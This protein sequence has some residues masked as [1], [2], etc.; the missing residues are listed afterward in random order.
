MNIDQVDLQ[1]PPHLQDYK[2]S[3]KILQM[4]EFQKRNFKIEKSFSPLE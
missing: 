2:K 1:E 3:F 4:L